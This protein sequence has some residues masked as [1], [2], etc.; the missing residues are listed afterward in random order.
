MTNFLCSVRPQELVGHLCN[1]SHVY[2]VYCQRDKPPKH[3]Q[4]KPQIDNISQGWVIHPSYHK[5]I[6]KLIFFKLDPS[7]RFYILIKSPFLVKVICFSIKAP[8]LE[9]RCSSMF[10]IQNILSL[11]IILCAIHSE[12]ENTACSPMPTTVSSFLFSR[13]QKGWPKILCQQQL[14]ILAS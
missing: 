9:L 5:A 4:N 11:N 8:I 10:A 6:P 12:S 7:E 14:I 3:R 13:H 2:F 1:T